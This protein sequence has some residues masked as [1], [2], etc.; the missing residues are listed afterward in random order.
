MS[1]IIFRA[2]VFI[3]ICIFVNWIILEAIQT[4][5]VK[6]VNM[7]YFNNMGKLNAI[8]NFGLSMKDGVYLGDVIQNSLESNLANV[9]IKMSTVQRRCIG[10]WIIALELAVIGI[11]TAITILANN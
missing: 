2:V 5:W 3:V 9:K 11:I 10:A 1:I 6:R 4:C 8:N 7:R